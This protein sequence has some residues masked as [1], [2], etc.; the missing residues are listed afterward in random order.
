[1]FLMITKIIVMPYMCVHFGT[2]NT[3]PLGY[4]WELYGAGEK[5][6][7]VGETEASWGG[8]VVWSPQDDLAKVG[9]EG[10]LFHGTLDELLPVGSPP[11]SGVAHSWSR[12]RARH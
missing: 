4:I 7:T 11:A 9:L 8:G 5:S 6:T 3:F 12:G 2:Q 10:N 1:M